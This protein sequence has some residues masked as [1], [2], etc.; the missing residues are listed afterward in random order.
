MLPAL[1]IFTLIFKDIKQYG[2]GT[3]T[4]CS[5]PNRSSPYRRS[6]DSSYNYLFAR[7]NKGV[8]ILRIEDTDQARLVD[9]AEEYIIESLRWCA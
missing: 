7:K 4:F 5:E 3:G 9:G 1:V 6:A 8:F 2:S